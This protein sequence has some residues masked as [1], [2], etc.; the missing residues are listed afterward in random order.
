MFRNSDVPFL[1]F[2]GVCLAIYL[3]VYAY[4]VM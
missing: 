1:I 3:I 2:V 4:G